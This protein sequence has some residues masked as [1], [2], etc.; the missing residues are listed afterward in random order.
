MA[1]SNYDANNILFRQQ[2]PPRVTPTVGVGQG[3]NPT[4]A[5]DQ[6]VSLGGTPMVGTPTI[7]TMPTGTPAWNQGFNPNT[8][9][10]QGVSTGGTSTGRSPLD[11]LNNVTP[12]TFASYANLYPTTA[13]VTPMGSNQATSKNKFTTPQLIGSD[14][15]SRLAA[16]ERKTSSD[17]IPY[18]LRTG[19]TTGTPV[20]TST[21]KTGDKAAANRSKNASTPR[22]G[23][24]GTSAPV[25]PSIP[26]INSVGATGS[27]INLNFGYTPDL[28]FTSSF[29][30]VIDPSLLSG[31][32]S[33]IQALRSPSTSVG[34]TRSPMGPAYEPEPSMFNTLA[35]WG[36]EAVDMLNPFSDDITPGAT[37][38][39]QGFL[40]PE[41]QLRLFGGTD[42]MGNKYRGALGPL[43]RGLGVLFRGWTGKE[44]IDIA[45]DMAAGQQAAY[46]QNM[47]AQAQAYN[48]AL[49]AQYRSQ[50]G[51]YEGKDEDVAKYMEENGIKV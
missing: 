22:S 21:G 36:G 30:S 4:Q 29:S 20:T 41:A 45:K 43:T 32:D 25:I 11:F 31:L 28:G 6:G 8:A 19:D 3:F 15:N 47:Q 42:A 33:S 12:D 49:E 40:S 18:S 50:S 5:W 44:S 48:T 2:Q 51:E 37:G 1:F 10:N 26:P 9:W 27:G 35:S 17:G 39:N 38:Y 7:G 46:Q 34:A 23:V 24:G 14:L 16:G 13:G